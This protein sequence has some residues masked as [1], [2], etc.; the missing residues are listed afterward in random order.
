[1]L[2]IIRHKHK[3]VRQIEFWVKARTYELVES[4]EKDLLVRAKDWAYDRTTVGDVVLIRA[5]KDNKEMRCVR[6]IVARRLYQR[7][8]D[9]INHEDLVRMAHGNAIQTLSY[10][11]RIYR[12]DQEEGNAV[13][14]ELAPLEEEQS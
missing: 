5:H 4:R 10:L 8:T 3:K 1:M 13:V 2:R 9:V 6:K 7:M 11:A 14:Y 12:L